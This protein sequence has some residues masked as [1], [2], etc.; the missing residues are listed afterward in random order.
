MATR[1]AA[2]KGIPVIELD[3]LFWVPGKKGTRPARWA[4]IQAD[5]VKAPEWILDGD[6]GPYDVVEPRL[7]AADAIIVLDFS[8]VRSLWRALRRSPER[9]D[10]WRWLITWRRRSRPFLMAAIAREAPNAEVYVLRTPKEVRR[11]LSDESASV[12]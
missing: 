6:L 4:A 10:F 5:L 2:M 12:S 8:L 7:R 11:F 3:S 9:L 1:L